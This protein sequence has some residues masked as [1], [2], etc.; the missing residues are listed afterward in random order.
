MLFDA[1]VQRTEFRTATL[2]VEA[3]DKV[4]AFHAAH[5]AMDDHDFDRD[6]TEHADEDV[7]C[8]CEVDSASGESAAPAAV[9]ESLARRRRLPHCAI[10]GTSVNNA[11][12]HVEWHAGLGD[13]IVVSEPVEYQ[14]H[15]CRRTVTCDG[16]GGIVFR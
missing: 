4:R 11:K 15:G 8:V 5:E 3:P 14:C 9:Y 1:I 10:C 16:T 2:R 7:L 12:A 6:E 13:W